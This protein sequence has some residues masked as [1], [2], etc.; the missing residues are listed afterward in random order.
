MT[1]ENVARLRPPA[2]WYPEGPNQQMRWWDGDAWGPPPVGASAVTQQ[3]A[4]PATGWMI[5]GWLG[6]V[7]FPLLGLASGIVLITRRHV[8]QGVVMIVVSCF[9][10]MI[11]A[12]ALADTSS[13]SGGYS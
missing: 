12:G 13:S 7:F 4:R 8:A 5:A 2:G 11:W 1:E 9:M 10:A 3:E 6:A